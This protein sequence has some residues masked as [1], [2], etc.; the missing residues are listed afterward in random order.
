MAV[1]IVRTRQEAIAALDAVA[2]YFKRAEPSSPVPIFIDRA[3]R[4][5]SKN[6]LEVLADIVPTA[7]PQA[8]EAGGLKGDN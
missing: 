4:L 8:R 2:E 5:V 1:G 7:V 3:K 6:F